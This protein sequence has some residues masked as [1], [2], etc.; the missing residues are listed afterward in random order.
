M[1]AKARPDRSVVVVIHTDDHSTG[2]AAGGE[3]WST[4]DLEVKR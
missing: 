1:V 3:Y 4:F 2:T